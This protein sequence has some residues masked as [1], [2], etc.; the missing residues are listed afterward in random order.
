MKFEE[1][2]TL[3][4]APRRTAGGPWSAASGLTNFHDK[5][6]ISSS[7]INQAC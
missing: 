1:L 3:P 6:L 2:T 7:L 5:N 4:D